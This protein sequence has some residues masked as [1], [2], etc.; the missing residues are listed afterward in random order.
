MT[1]L[2][3]L[4]EH[5]TEAIRELNHRTRHRDAFTDPT[6][7]SELIAEL[8][9]LAGMLPQLLDQHRRWL[10]NEHHNTPLR[11]D[12]DIDPGELVCL[13]AAQLTRASHY[14]HALADTLDNAHQHVAHLATG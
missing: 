8:A 3:H 4:G 14:A 1:S 11:V 5:A 12:N 13:A 10:H 9:A 7:L 2:L 6:Q